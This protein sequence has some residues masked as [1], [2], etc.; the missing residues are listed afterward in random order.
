VDGLFKARAA[1]ARVGEGCWNS[2][3]SIT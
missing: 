1:R 3:R 2:H